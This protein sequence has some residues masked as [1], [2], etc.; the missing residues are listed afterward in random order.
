MAL[1]DSFG[2]VDTSDRDPRRSGGSGGSAH[3]GKTVKKGKSKRKKPGAASAGRWLKRIALLVVGTVVLGGVALAGLFLFYARDLP[4][5]QAIREF[6]PKQM[7]RV[8]D[9]NGQVIGELGEERRTLVPL[10]EI[11]KH[12]VQAVVA[13]EDATFFENPGLDIKGVVKAFVENVIQRKRAPGRSTITQQVVKLLLLSPERTVAR[14]IKELALAYRLTNS[15]S[16]NEIMET[17]LNQIYYGHGRYGCEEAAQYFFGKSVRKVDTGEAALLAGI[18]QLPERLSPIKHPEAA[19]TRQRYVLGRMAELGFL[20]QAKAEQLAKSPIKIVRTETSVAEAP[21]VTSLASHAAYDHL[22]ADAYATQGGNVDTTIDLKLQQ[23]ARQA[24]EK[25]LEALDARQG[26]T[27]PLRRLKGKALDAF[28]DQTGK[29]LGKDD[30]ARRKALLTGRI[31]EAVVARVDKATATNPPLL[32]LNAGGVP[33]VVDLSREDRY[34]KGKPALSERFAAGDVVR[35]KAIGAPGPNS[36]DAIPAQLELGP[37]AA[38]VVLDV[39]TGE[40]RALVGGYGYRASQFDRSQQARRQPGSAFKPFVFATAIASRRFTAASVMNDA[41]EVYDLWKPKNYEKENFRGPVRLREALAHSIN[42]VAIRL[43]SEVGV[44]ALKDV[45]TRMGITSAITDEMGLSLAL[46]SLTVTPFEL[47]QAYLPLFNGGMRVVPR[48]V[49]RVAGEDTPPPLEPTRALDS[50]T[51]FVVLSMMKSVVTEGTGR[52]ATSLGRPVSGKTGTSNGQRDAWFVGG[53]PDLLAAVWVGFDDMQM[54]G[55]GETGGGAA[56]P[57]WVDFMTK[58]S[59]GQPVR[60]FPQPPSIEVQTIDRKTGLLAAPGGE[61]IEEVFI[62]G[63]APVDSA[64]AE[65][66][67]QSADELLL[68][69]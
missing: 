42:T 55:R 14:K 62:H 48:V 18:P 43:L 6:Q 46:G 64:P 1:D 47:A 41:P 54:L 39:A 22:G 30:A 27:K 67:A 9:R 19:K 56:L 50:E 25:G 29:R 8:L 5:L 38:M 28:V 15:L 2:G 63:T 37:Q 33:M 51:A 24:L 59:A 17:Y 4:S 3:K 44:P 26:Y 35:V 57:M 23:F 58:A 45:T 31:L 34:A 21:E 53:T 13:A 20:P 66:E 61:G 32:Q 12:M 49:V 60:D 40:L 7:M 10:A 36:D 52:A 68:T 16:K 69:Q 11:P 65:G